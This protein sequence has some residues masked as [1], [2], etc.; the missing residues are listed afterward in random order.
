MPRTISGEDLINAAYRRADLVGAT[1]RHP[2]DQVLSYVNEGAAEL[3]DLLVEARGRAY[4]RATPWPI[5]TALSTSR[6]ALP[7][8]FYQ[9]ISIRLAGAYGYTLDPFDPQDEPWLRMPQG[10]VDQPSRYELQPGFVE[11]LPLSSAGLPIVV[12]WIPTCPLLTDTTTSVFDGINGW[13]PYIIY[14]AAR[15]MLFKDGEKDDAA[16]QDGA[17]AALAKRIGK[18]APQRDRFRAEKVKNVRNRAFTLG[19]R[20]W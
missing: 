9:L 15:E 10:P 2:R 17:L 13:E 5:T 19:N 11:I 3:Y 6:Y 16:A 14:Y 8:T 12:D 4:Y 18:L 7:P 1:D 20:R